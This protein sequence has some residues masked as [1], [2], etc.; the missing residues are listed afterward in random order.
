MITPEEQ[1]LIDWSAKTWKANS[2]AL[3]KDGKPSVNGPE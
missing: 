3:T 2:G 1:A